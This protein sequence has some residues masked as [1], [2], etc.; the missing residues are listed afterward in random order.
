MKIIGNLHIEDELFTDEFC[1]ELEIT[2]ELL[3]KIK[4]FSDKARE[5]DVYE[6]TDFRYD[7]VGYSGSLYDA[8]TAEEDFEAIKAEK[9]SYQRLDCVLLH[10]SDGRFRF[11]GYLKQTSIMFSTGFLAI[12][13]VDPE[14]AEKEGTILNLEM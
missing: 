3:D 7:L 13:Q 2:D 14:V 1:Y 5:L 11:T 12:C 6:I 8:D 9:D 4:F 10:G